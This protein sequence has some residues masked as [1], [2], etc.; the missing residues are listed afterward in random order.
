M[1]EGLFTDAGRVAGEPTPASL[2][3]SEAQSKALYDEAA[4]LA[5]GPDAL[6]AA[7]A[8]AANTLSPAQADEYNRRLVD[9]QQSAGAVREL[10]DRKGGAATSAAEF[11]RLSHASARGDAAATARIA[12]TPLET[13]QRFMN[14]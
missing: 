10:L 11:R 1:P 7:L 14:T 13:C 3:P 2:T 4:R 5:G 9:A 8:H 12:A 6:R